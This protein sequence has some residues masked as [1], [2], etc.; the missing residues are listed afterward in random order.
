MTNANLALGAGSRRRPVLRDI[1]VTVPD[2]E[3]LSVVGPSGSGKSTLLGVLAGLTALDS[4]RIEL[5]GAHAERPPG[6]VFQDPLLL[7]W[8]NVVDN[9]TL[10]LRFGRSRRNVTPRPGPTTVPGHPAGRTR[11]QPGP[12]GR[13][14]GRRAQRRARA[15]A[16][17]DELGIGE[18]A[19]RFPDELSGGQAHRVA[20]A[21]TI[22]VT[23]GILLL[24]EP[25]AALDPRTRRDLQDWLLALRE[26]L[27]LTIV[28]VTHDVDEALKLGD[29]IAVLSTT[30]HGLHVVDNTVDVGPG[31]CRDT[32]RAEV[33]DR[34]GV[35]LP[36]A[37]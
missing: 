21:R 2:G 35:S 18:L 27:G 16:L 25:F 4:G 37:G 19:D 36:A 3:L 28:L 30:D 15:G 24:D 26:R 17:L 34:L 29:R 13:L 10:G 1:D 23:S 9:V 22:L 6:I 7:P 31:R 11:F 8:L 5:G 14:Q 33:L 32:T 12:G 20:I